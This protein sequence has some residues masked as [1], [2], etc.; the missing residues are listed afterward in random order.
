MTTQ[1]ILD[2][3]VILLLVPTIVYAIILNRRLV[4]L[5]RSRDELG[6]IVASF[7]DATMR[8]EAGIPKLKKATTEAN[9]TL[10]DRVD[11]AQTLRDD[12]AFMVQR[13]EEL[14]NRLEAGVKAARVDVGTAPTA[15]V[16]AA[17]S[18]YGAAAPAP[19]RGPAGRTTPTTTPAGTPGNTVATPAVAEA[20]PPAP[21]LI[22]TAAVDL[23]VR[24][25]EMTATL[26]RVVDLAYA[27]GGYLVQRT[28]AQVQVRV[29]S[30]RFRE[31]V[32]RVEELADVLHRSINAQDVSEEFNDLEVRLTNLRAVRHRLEEFLARAANVAEALRVEQELERVTQEMDRIEGRMHFLRARATF[33]LVTVTAHPRSEAVVAPDPLPGP[34]VR[35]PLDLPVQWLELL[36]LGRLLQIR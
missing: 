8:A 28:D 22:Y 26:D 5:R 7:N 14:A 21:M 11:K 10:K 19:A 18:T 33:S 13:A 4:A 12:L 27:M 16:S 1:T 32:R 9:Q 20:T 3:V 29:P 6:R 24:R 30:S 35:R 23:S 17:A 25:A 2:I 15:P 34:S 36:G 31:G